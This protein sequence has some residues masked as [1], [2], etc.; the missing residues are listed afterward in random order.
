[1]STLS[2][3]ETSI[4]PAWGSSYRLIASE[5]WKA[6]SAVKG[7]AA[8]EALAEYAAP[9]PCMRV[10]DVATGTGEPAISIAMRVGPQGHLT[11][12]DISGELLEV[13]RARASE[14]GLQNFVTEQADAHALPFAEH[15]FDLATSRFGV[16]FFR[17]PA[18]V[19]G[20]MRRILRPEARAGFA[21]WGSPGL[22]K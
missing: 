19:L 13:A 12:L 1:M 10:R 22:C 21:A 4:E 11:A 15:H 7:K 2:K 3:P 20:E 5:K 8:T 9:Q 14:R 17:D 18:L 6:K 16:M